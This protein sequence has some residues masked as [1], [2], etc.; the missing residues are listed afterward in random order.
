MNRLATHLVNKHPDEHKNS[1]SMPW[2]QYNRQAEVHDDFS[3][4][5]RTGDVLEP[6]TSGYWVAATAGSFQSGKN[7]VSRQL[8]EP[9][10][11]KYRHS[12]PM[13]PSNILQK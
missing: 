3:E 13:V 2:P 12:E 6:V 8:V 4:V 5:V 7:L 9:G 11:N 1:S 10:P